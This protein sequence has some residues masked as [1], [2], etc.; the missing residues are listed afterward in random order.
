MTKI[1]NDVTTENQNTFKVSVIPHT[2]TN[3]TL[4]NFKVGD[5]IILESDVLAKYIE[6]LMIKEDNTN[7][8]ITLEFLREN[9]F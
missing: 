1:I 2:Y 4:S 6:K 7:S 3:T 9:G 8:N 5:N